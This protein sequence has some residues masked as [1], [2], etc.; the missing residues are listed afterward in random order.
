MGG[1]TCPPVGVKKVILKQFMVVA[2]DHS[3]NDMA[4]DEDDSWKS[5]LVKNGFEVVTVTERLGENDQFANIFVNH[6]A[7]AGRDAGIELK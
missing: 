5:I 7:D 3:I 1:K 2:G 6:A 4:G